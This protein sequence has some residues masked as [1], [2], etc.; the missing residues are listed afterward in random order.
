[1]WWEQAAWIA[2]VIAA[3]IAAVALRRQS[4]QVRASLLL[5][6]YE[7]WEG[8]AE[9]RGAFTLFYQSVGKAVR[10]AHSNL[11]NE[12][13]I[14]HLRAEF[15]RQLADLK[16]RDAKEFSQFV[17][18]VSFFELLGMYVKK[19]YLPLCDIV[20]MYK[21]PILEIELSFRDFVPVWQSEAH[22]S[23][24]LFVNALYLMRR[25]S[26]CDRHPWLAWLIGWC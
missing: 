2:T 16:A 8:L 21:G 10:K 23:N 15:V 5:N 6:V 19:R 12:A 26:F 13:Q 3:L 9:A 24:G 11:Q 17:A 20:D 7:R 25:V 4:F 22:V 18:F 14:P 1:V